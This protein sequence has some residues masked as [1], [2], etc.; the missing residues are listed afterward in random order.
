MLHCIMHYKLKLCV[1]PKYT[2]HLFNFSY[3]LTRGKM[4]DN[5]MLI[6]S[7]FSF[8][9]KCTAIYTYRSVHLVLK[10]YYKHTQLLLLLS[11]I[12]FKTI[13]ISYLFRVW[14]ENNTRFFY[15]FKYKYLKKCILTKKN[16]LHKVKCMF[17]TEH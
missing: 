2:P 4:F 3:L 16:L 17:T 9:Y 11:F 6:F 8:K 1:K 15:F 13:F 14:F 5:H 7:Y 12:F 10:F